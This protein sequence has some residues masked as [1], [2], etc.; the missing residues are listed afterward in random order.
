MIRI[1]NVQ[2]TASFQE[3]IIARKVGILLRN[4]LSKGFEINNHY[5]IFIKMIALNH[6]FPLLQNMV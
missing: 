6:F 3:P 4:T 1:A 2:S 5:S